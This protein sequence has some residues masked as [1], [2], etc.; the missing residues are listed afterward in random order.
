MC[1]SLVLSNSVTII[2]N[3][4]N[5]DFWQYPIHQCEF[6]FYKTM[7]NL[8]WI[9]YN[10]SYLFGA[11]LSDDRNGLTSHGIYVLPYVLAFKNS[12]HH[13]SSLFYCLYAPTWQLSDFVIQDEQDYLL[14]YCIDY[15]TFTLS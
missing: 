2:V 11:I 4:K 15:S 13:S 6:H 8:K 12:F 1:G 14:Y 5:K 10:R 3:I 7:Q 9:D